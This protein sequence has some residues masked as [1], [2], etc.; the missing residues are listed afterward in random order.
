MHEYIYIYIYDG[1]FI[2]HG[3]SFFFSRKYANTGNLV[4]DM[5]FLMLPPD[6]VWV[7]ESLVGDKQKTWNLKSSLYYGIQCTTWTN[8]TCLTA[9]ILQNSLPG[10]P[11]FVAIDSVIK[12]MCNSQ[13]RKIKRTI[14]RVACL[15]VSGTKKIITYLFRI[16]FRDVLPC[17]GSGI[18]EAVRTS[19]TSVDNH[20]TWQYIPEDN[21]EHHTRRRDNLKSQITYLYNI[22]C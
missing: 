9:K 19:E 12:G 1:W 5:Y 13:Q 22:V 15:S 11:R 8:T 10:C 7:Q 6:W 18:M 21:S 3:N 16:V 20:F 14:G 2:S 4:C 17:K